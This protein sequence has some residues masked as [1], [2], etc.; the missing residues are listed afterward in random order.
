MSDLTH[1]PR[2]PEDPVEAA[3]LDVESVM[4]QLFSPDPVDAFVVDELPDGSAGVIADHERDDPPVAV[5]WTF[6][7]T[8]DRD[9]AGIDATGASVT[10]RGVTVLSGR[11]GHREYRRFV[12]WADV[13]GQVGL[14]LGRRPMVPSPQRD[15]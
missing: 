11:P 13:A 2:E 4:S 9:G 15:G 10:I 7:G 14:T 3:R 5:V 1:D 6:R 8:H 12:D